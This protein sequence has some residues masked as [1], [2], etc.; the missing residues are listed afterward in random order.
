M[1]SEVET[2]RQRML[3]E[4]ERTRQE[5]QR[6]NVQERFLESKTRA[7]TM[8]AQEAVLNLIA[9]R[10]LASARTQESEQAKMRIYMDRALMEMGIPGARAMEELYQRHPWLRQVKEF[11][12]GN[13]VGTGVGLGA[14]GAIGAAG[15]MKGKWGEARRHPNEDFGKMVPGKPKR[16]K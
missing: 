6:T 14:A 11:G 4:Q 2:I 1:D 8:A 15:Y 10:G 16:R 5:V 9:E 3:Q 13:L 12:G 7:E